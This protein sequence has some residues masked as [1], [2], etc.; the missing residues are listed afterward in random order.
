ME[1]LDCFDYCSFVVSSKIRKYE[2]GE[3]FDDQFYLF[4]H[5]KSAEIFLFQLESVLAICV[6]PR[7]ESI[8]SRLCFLGVFFFFWHTII[9]GILL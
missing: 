3:V 9:H 4:T 5:Y 1:S 8:S 6:F 7:T 2:Y